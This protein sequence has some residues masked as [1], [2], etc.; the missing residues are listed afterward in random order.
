M[1]TVKKRKLNVDFIKKKKGKEKGVSFSLNLLQVFEVA[2]T[3][4]LFVSDFLFLSLSTELSAY[5][6]CILM[7]TFTLIVL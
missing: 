1:K 6:I 3:F 4:S 5:T 2:L 7:W